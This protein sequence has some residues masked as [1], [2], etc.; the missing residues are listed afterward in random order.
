MQHQWAETDV[1][2][3]E[4][5]TYAPKGEKCRRC[6]KPFGSLEAVRRVQPSGEEPNGRPYAHMRCAEAGDE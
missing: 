3:G 6:H 5:T 4:Y 2:G 1:R